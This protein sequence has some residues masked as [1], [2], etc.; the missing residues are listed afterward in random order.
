MWLHSNIPSCWL[1]SICSICS[2]FLFSYCSAFSY[3][4]CILLI[5]LF[6]IPFY[7]HHKPIIYTQQKFVIL[8]QGLQYTPVN[9]NQPSHN[10]PLSMQYTDLKQCTPNSSLPLFVQYC[11]KL[12]FYVWC[13]HNF[14][15]IRF[16]LEQFK[17]RK[18]LILFYLNLF[19][20]ALRIFVSKFLPGNHIPSA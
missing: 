4:N 1:F 2:L 3:I 12:H 5:G 18:K 15:L 8:L 10:I 6:I 13:E 20:S 7:F 17:I 14:A 11:H 19:Q 16:I 9:Q